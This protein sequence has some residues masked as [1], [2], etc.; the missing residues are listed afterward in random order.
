MDTCHPL[1]GCSFLPNAAT[2][3][4]GDAC[5][6][7][8]SCAFGKCVGDKLSCHDGN[9]CTDDACAPASGC[10]HTNNFDICDDSNAC[11]LP[12]RCEAGNCVG[13]VVICDD[14][15]TCTDDLCDIGT[16]CT[17]AFNTSPC[18][19]GLYCTV[20][21]ACW[22]GACLGDVVRECGMYDKDCEASVCN[23]EAKSC[24]LVLRADGDPCEDGLFCSIDDQCVAGVCAAG[25]QRDCSPWTGEATV[26]VCKEAES[27][28]AAV[29]TDGP[30][31]PEEPDS[32]PDSDADVFT[33]D[34]A[35]PDATADTPPAV[36]VGTKTPS[37]GG[38]QVSGGCTQGD[39]RGGP[40]AWIALILA[41]L[42]FW[43]ARPARRT[44]Q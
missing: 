41:L 32:A 44:R 21:Q 26:G 23:E 40:L 16:G 11:T 10:L 35:G 1:S 36:L 7:S 5:T 39:T 33:D 3:N 4:D 2:C 9:P 29:P 42:A 25:I 43:R 27:R 34:T 24:V 22:D 19:D 8:D 17:H 18:E 13:D 20:D 15:N 38:G 14:D 31:E 30:L 12:D 6:I 28:C 37:L